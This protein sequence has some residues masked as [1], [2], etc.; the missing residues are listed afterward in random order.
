MS[1]YIITLAIAAAVGTAAFT[2]ATAASKRSNSQLQQTTTTQSKLANN[3]YRVHRFKTWCT[4]PLKPAK[5]NISF[6]NRE[7]R[8]CYRT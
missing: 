3:P 2:P 8:G 6:A 1:R 4:L 5:S 7:A